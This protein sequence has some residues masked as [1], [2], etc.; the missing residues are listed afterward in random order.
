MVC[1]KL[2]IQFLVVGGIGTAK[3]LHGTVQLIYIVKNILGA[4]LLH[5]SFQASIPVEVLAGVG[6]NVH[7]NAFGLLLLVLH[8][9]YACQIQTTAH[10]IVTYGLG[11]DYLLGIA[12]HVQSLILLALAHQL[13]GKGSEQTTMCV[14]HAQ[15]S[16][17][18]IY[19]GIVQTTEAELVSVIEKI[20]EN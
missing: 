8:Q 13:H 2:L 3:N 16:L 6:G 4:G 19:V 20:K 18:Q 12:Y 1:L 9:P 11:W 14:A 10:I 15:N 5:T 7:G 17:V